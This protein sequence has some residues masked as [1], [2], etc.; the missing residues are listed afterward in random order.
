[1]PETLSSGRDPP[2]RFAKTYRFSDRFIPLFGGSFFVDLFPKGE[3]NPAPALAV[4][5]GLS[6][7]ERLH[8]TY[9][10]RE[11]AAR[12]WILFSMQGMSFLQYSI[13]S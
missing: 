12:E 4:C 8:Q 3:R 1:M 9:T 11:T 13:P 7:V 5:Q 6:H 2:G 10:I